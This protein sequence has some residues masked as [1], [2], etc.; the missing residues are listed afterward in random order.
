MTDTRMMGLGPQKARATL[1]P[2]RAGSGQGGHHGHLGPLSPRALLREHS[3][4]S[5]PWRAGRPAAH[6]LPSRC[7]EQALP[8]L[9]GCFREQQSKT[10][11]QTQQTYFF[12]SL[13]IKKGKKKSQQMLNKAKSSPHCTQ[14]G[15]SESR[16]RGLG[17]PGPSRPWLCGGALAGL[18]PGGSDTGALPFPAGC[19]SVALPGGLEEL[20]LLGSGR[21]RRRQAGKRG[22]GTLAG[23]QAP[24][25]QSPTIPREARIRAAQR[26]TSWYSN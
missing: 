4:D 21:Q 7:A 9:Q 25:G 13:N 6:C 10:N 15:D 2:C 17:S 23:M 1:R 19:G 12:D 20:S 5:R 11:S 16:W 8:P 22:D 14:D 26:Q 24:A 3:E 18:G